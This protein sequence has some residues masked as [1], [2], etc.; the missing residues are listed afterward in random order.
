MT[1]DEGN[2][3]NTG[4]PEAGEPERRRPSGGLSA[5]VVA[6]A[7]STLPRNTQ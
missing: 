2:G 3:E 4:S 5:S 1:A 7:G 6:F